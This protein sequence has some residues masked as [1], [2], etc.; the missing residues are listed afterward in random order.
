VKAVTA[1]QVVAAMNSTCG[2]SN[3]VDATLLPEAK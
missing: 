2:A 3:N 1:A